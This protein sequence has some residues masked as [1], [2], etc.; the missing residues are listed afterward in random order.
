MIKVNRKK[1]AL[2]NIK[3]AEEE[4]MDAS[5]AK[6]VLFIWDLTAEVWSLKDKQSAKR[7]LQRNHTKFIKTPR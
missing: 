5:P 6:R 3:D 7:R 4:F 2:K 1:V